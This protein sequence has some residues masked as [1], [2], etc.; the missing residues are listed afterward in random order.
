[1]EE[2]AEWIGRA[3]A[4]QFL[5]ALVRQLRELAALERMWC[6]PA[7]APGSMPREEQP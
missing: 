6:L 4:V 1:M 5:N 7:R 2:S 3:F